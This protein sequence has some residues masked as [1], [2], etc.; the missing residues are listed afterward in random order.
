MMA[1][2]AVPPALMSL[3]VMSV[4]SKHRRTNSAVRVRPLPRYHI[5]TAVAPSIS[6]TSTC[7]PARRLASASS[8]RADQTS[9][10]SLI[11][12]PCRRPAPGRRPDG[13]CSA[14]TPLREPGARCAVRAW[15][16]AVRRDERDRDDGED[17][18]LG[19]RSAAEPGRDGRGHRADGEH[20][21]LGHRGEDE[22]NA[23]P[24]G[25]DQPPHPCVDV[26][27]VMVGPRAQSATGCG[28]VRRQPAAGPARSSGRRCA[29]R[30]AAGRSRARGC[31]RSARS[32]CGP[33]ASTLP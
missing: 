10:A 7:C 27:M 32:P 19:H 23:Q 14:S 33:A 21:E 20:A 5:T 1:F 28:A 26:H 22:R 11:R 17:E 2:I 30:P 24:D 15:P 9:P 6:T 13:P 4:R 16:S 3:M 29:P 12:P 25:G 31:G 8:A 18:D